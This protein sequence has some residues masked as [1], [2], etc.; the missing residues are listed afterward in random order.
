LALAGYR[1]CHLIILLTSTNA[2]LRLSGISILQDRV[3]MTATMLVP[4]PV[5][6]AYL[7]RQ[8]HAWPAA[9]MR[10]LNRATR[11]S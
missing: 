7:R 3:C 1:K 9:D 10:A 5:F 11:F 6:E 2:K 4:E 8:M